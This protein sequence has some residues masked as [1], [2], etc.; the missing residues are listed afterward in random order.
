MQG[1]IDIKQSQVL[2][3]N[4]PGGKTRAGQ[5]SD[6]PMGRPDLSTGQRF[7]PSCGPVGGQRIYHCYQY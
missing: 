6:S 7:G 4:K 3:R 5:E 2:R 1:T